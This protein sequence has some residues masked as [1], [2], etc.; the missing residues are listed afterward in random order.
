MTFFVFS[1]DNKVTSKVGIPPFLDTGGLDK[2]PV[3]LCKS[4]KSKH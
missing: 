1:V 3:I 4:T 2:D